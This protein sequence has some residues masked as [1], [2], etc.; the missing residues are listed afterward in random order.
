MA[1]DK[2][3]CAVEN[4][5]CCKR[6]KAVYKNLVLKKGLVYWP[7]ENSFYCNTDHV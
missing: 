6:L 1:F 2:F 7:A 3:L 5:T 4:E